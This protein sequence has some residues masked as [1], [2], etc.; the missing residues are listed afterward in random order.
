M[1]R[2]R[3]HARGRR[4][5]P[6]TRPCLRLGCRRRHAEIWN[7]LSP[8]NHLNSLINACSIPRTHFNVNHHLINKNLVIFIRFVEF[9]FALRKSMVAPKHLRN[10]IL[11]IMLFE[12]LAKT[13]LIYHHI[14]NETLKN[15]VTVK[16]NF[17]DTR[18]IFAIKFTTTSSDRTTESI[19]S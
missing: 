5:E 6:V 15:F 1:P 19:E 17:L 3:A 4:I 9:E 12:E 10:I 8:V 2:A 7:F 16:G 18:S 13:Q 14:A 11:I